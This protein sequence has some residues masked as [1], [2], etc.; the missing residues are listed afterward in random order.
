MKRTVFSAAESIGL[1]IYGGDCIVSEDGAIYIIDMNDF[2][3]FSAI[4][5][6]AAGEIAEYIINRITEER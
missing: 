4:R 2:P 6:E 5:D 1:E 3:S